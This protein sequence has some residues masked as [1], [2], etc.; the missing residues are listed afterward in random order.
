[1]HVPYSMDDS[2]PDLHCGMGGHGY[3]YPHDDRDLCSPWGDP[4]PIPQPKPMY[5]FMNE[6]ELV[7]SEV[8]HRLML[9]TIACKERQIDELRQEI[10]KMM[11]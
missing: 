11:E 6:L 7:Q 9:K 4:K 2:E 3:D 1:M 5:V 8:F 10:I